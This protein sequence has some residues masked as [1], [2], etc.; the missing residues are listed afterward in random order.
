ML[1]Q[2][3]YGSKIS[4]RILNDLKIEVGDFK[5]STGITPTLVA[6]MVGHNPASEIYVNK[7]IN[8]CDNVGIMAYKI[9]V[10][11]D[12]DQLMKAIS[13]CNNEDHIH[14][15]ILQL[16]LP[17]GWEPNQYF[18]MFNP[19]K[20]VD[21]FHPEN[22]GLLVQGKPRFKP[23]TPHAIQVMLKESGIKVAGKKIVI[24]NRSNVVGR[25]L[26]SM[27]I[28]D[29]DNF[30]NATVTV[31]HDKTPAPLLKSITQTADI[32]VVAVGKPNFLTVDMV[33]N[34]VIVIDVGINRIDNKVV[35]D[36]HPEVY[37]ITQAYSPV[38]NGVGPMTIAMLLRNTL[39]AAKMQVYNQ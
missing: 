14:G 35:G 18:K 2:I 23:C 17:V 1:S 34:G 28:Q 4:T 37:P 3:I 9:Q 24:I 38:P 20:D 25:P 6:L 15:Y 27:F 11:Q 10:D 31:C 39:L 22:V 8:A 36:V 21:V 19:L 33:K 16:P 32:I 7:K 13:E 5:K 26:S 29:C 12:Q 30:G